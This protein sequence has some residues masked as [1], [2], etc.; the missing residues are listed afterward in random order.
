MATYPC[1]VCKIHVRPRQHGCFTTVI[2]LKYRQLSAFYFFPKSCLP[3]NADITEPKIYYILKKKTYKHN[4]NNNENLR[5]DRL[6]LDRLG[7][8]RLRAGLVWGRNDSKSVKTMLDSS[9]NLQMS[10]KAIFGMV[11]YFI[12]VLFKSGCFQGQ[13]CSQY[14]PF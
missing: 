13:C 12:S 8:E 2:S 11:D 4:N 6:G 5:P 3:S 9:L 1:V 14:C 10:Y 7:P